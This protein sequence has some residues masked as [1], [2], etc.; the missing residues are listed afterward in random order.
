M[1]KTNTFPAAGYANGSQGRMIGIVH[2]DSDYILP[3]GSPGEMIMIPPPRFI[4]MEVHHK[5]KEKKTSIFPCEKQQA[6]LEYKRDKKDFVYKCWSNMVVLTFALTIHETQGQTLPRIILLLGRLPGFNVGKITW[7]LLYVALSRTRKLSNIKFFPTGSSKYYHSMYFAHLKKLSMPENL[8]RWLRSYVNHS[9]DRNILRNEHLQKVRKVEERLKRLGELKT[10]RLGWVELHFLVKQM[11]HKATTRDNKMNLFCKLKEHM[12]KRLLWKASKDAKPVKR[13]ENRRRKRRN[14]KMEAVSSQ[15]CKSS[16]RPS[17]RL[18]GKKSKKILVP[19]PQHEEHISFKGLSN[20]GQTCYFNA[21]VQCLLHC[22]LFKQAIENV[23]RAA[24]SVSVLRELRL[25]FNKMSRKTSSRYLSTARCFSA[26]MGIP[27]CGRA[28]MHE[29][30]QE[31]AGEFFLILIEYFREKFRPLADIFEGNSRSIITCQHCSST[32]TTMQPF[33][34]LALCFPVSNNKQDQ[35]NVASTHDIY[36]LL[37]DF[38]RPEIISGYHCTQCATH[39]PAKKKLDILSTPKVLVLQLKRFSGL[40]KIDDFV[41][42]PTQ[43]RVK[44]V[45]AGSE[46]HHSYRIS[47]VVFHRGPT[48]ASGHYISYVNA[49]GKWLE[50]DDS[51]IREVRWEMVRDMKVYLLFYVRHL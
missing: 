35:H 10:K 38:F 13:K 25:L 16:F 12:V 43:L 36:T 41:K 15:K 47:G 21:I 20:L 18:K 2:D 27:Q 49:E 34:L 50:A 48:I 32:T 23:P 30:K 24:L 3:S 19:Q 26:A 44:F 45:G 14:Q 28:H 51:S 33:K 29:D 37:D 7:P 42:F 46:R 22:P 1:L 9:W 31:D 17:K 6:T 5:G 11:G 39:H 40:Q 4:I 8:K